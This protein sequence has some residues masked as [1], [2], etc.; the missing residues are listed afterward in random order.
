M[1]A[2]DKDDSERERRR[3]SSQQNESTAEESKE[4]N[5]PIVFFKS[6]DLGR[7][8]SVEVSLVHAQ[9]KEYV[10]DR[11]QQSQANSTLVRNRKVARFSHSRK[12]L[13]EVLA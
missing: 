5:L 3:V 9:V 12:H 13:C 11:L 7:T 2:E 1:D 8:C 4:W 10:M 6:R